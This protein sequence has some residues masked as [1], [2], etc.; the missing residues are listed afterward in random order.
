MSADRANHA[1]ELLD[2]PF[3]W[4]RLVELA[5]VHRLFPLLYWHVTRTLARDFP[6]EI[7]QQLHRRFLGDVAHSLLLIRDLVEIV[8][9]LERRGIQVIPFKGPALAE[10]LYGNAALRQCVDLDIL[11]AGGCG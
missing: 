2:Q 11:L 6:Q 7:G 9:L 10:S 5:D 4:S 3:D 8:D 1:L